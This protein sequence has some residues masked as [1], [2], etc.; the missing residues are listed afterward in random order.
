[1]HGCNTGFSKDDVRTVLAGRARALNRCPG[2]TTGVSVQDLT[3]KCLD[4]VFR[5]LCPG[6]V[7]YEEALRAKRIDRHGRPYAIGGACHPIKEVVGWTGD[8]RA[9]VRCVPKQSRAS[10][11]EDFLRM[12]QAERPEFE[13]FVMHMRA[14]DERARARA[15]RRRGVATPLGLSRRCPDGSTGILIPDNTV[16]GTVPVFTLVC[17]GDDAAPHLAGLGDAASDLRSLPLP[18]ALER[19]LATGAP[20]PAWRRDLGAATA[21][22]P[23]WVYG[24]G[25]VLAILLAAKAYKTWRDEPVKR[26]AK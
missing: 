24:A 10:E 11:L 13:E 3:A 22:I 18:G 19:Y 17:P 4:P 12:P 8:P 9:P 6:E 26:E 15:S 7:G 23:R 25:A 21:Q 16:H 20:M 1:M 2:G 5:T 14:A